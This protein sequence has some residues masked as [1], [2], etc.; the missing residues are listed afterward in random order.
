ML[1][2]PDSGSSRWTGRIVS[3][4]A[5][6]RNS[7]SS[8][9]RWTA[10][11]AVSEDEPIVYPGLSERLRVVFRRHARRRSEANN[12]DRLS[13]RRARAAVRS[14]ERSAGSSE[15]SAASNSPRRARTPS[16]R[17]ARRAASHRNRHRFPRTVVPGSGVSRGRVRA[18]AAFDTLVFLGGFS[19]VV[20]SPCRI[21]HQRPGG[22]RQRAR[23]AVRLGGD[24]GDLGRLISG[25]QSTPTF[26]DRDASAPG[27]YGRV[28][29]C[30]GSSARLTA[31][32]SGTNTRTP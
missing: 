25:V 21:R 15:T 27:E 28:G 19:L 32:D 30:N 3:V 31:P 24:A 17:R 13:R 4:T 18:R 2:S 12:P 7:V 23:P 6:A 26:M 16:S 8:A 20:R 1:A 22:R 5:N 9:T 11:P 14:C 10:F 29:Q